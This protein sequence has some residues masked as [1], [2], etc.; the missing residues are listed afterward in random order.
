MHFQYHVRSSQLFRLP[1]SVHLY[2]K[3]AR[4]QILHPLGHK[5]FLESSNLGKTSLIFM[6]GFFDCGFARVA[7][8]NSVYDENGKVIYD[9][10]T[11]LQKFLSTFGDNK[12]A[13]AVSQKTFDKRLPTLLKNFNKWQGED[14]S[15]YLDHFN[16]VAWNCLSALK[17]GLHSILNCKECQINHVVFQSLFPL[18]TN[19]LKGDDPVSASVKQAAKLRKSSKAVKPSAATIKDTAKNI[20]L[21]INQPFKNLYNTD[22]AE[23]LAKVPEIGLTK[24]KT[25][26]EKQKERREATRRMKNKTEEQWSKVDCDTML[27]TRQSFRQRDLQ[28]KSLYFE[29]TEEAKNRSTKRKALEEAGLRKKKR[30][31]PD[32]A[33]VTFDKEGLLQEVNS[34]KKGKKV[35]INCRGNT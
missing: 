23:A 17:K 22:L 13:F 35:R 34:M 6:A 26:A 25:K 8:R 24:S 28:R 20:Y 32:P 9:K 10:G 5:E 1:F 31:S 27:G 7:A 4:F 12:E 16:Y 29:S 3:A 15:K 33:S 30:H 19:R 14:K 18:R 2:F 11:R 21:K